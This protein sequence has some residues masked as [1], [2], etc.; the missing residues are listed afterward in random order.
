M[1]VRCPTCGGY[2]KVP[3]AY[4]AGTVMGYVGPDGENWPHEL[5]QTCGMSGWVDV[6]IKPADPEKTYRVIVGE[7]FEVLPGAPSVSTVV[8]TKFTPTTTGWPVFTSCV[9]T[10]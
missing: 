6:E 3:K 7:A 1:R 5:C 10:W 4:P 9:S 8:S 2:G